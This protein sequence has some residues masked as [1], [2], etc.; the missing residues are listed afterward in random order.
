MPLYSFRLYVPASPD[1]VV[2]R[3]RAIVREC[4]SFWESLRG[5]WLRTN[6]SG[7]PFLGSVKGNSFHLCRN[8]NYRNSFL[9]RIRGR[10]GSVQG[11]AR[12]G[13]VMFMHPLVFLFMLGWLGSVGYGA[14]REFGAT[15][16]L[17]YIPV[18]MFIFGLALSMGG[19][20]PE[21]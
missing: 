7:P 16:A 3:L 17:S 13:V 5:S 10:V 9:P 18:V 8:I 14:W 19:F 20:F 15:S 12:V 11:G 2:E 6:P 21:A 4:P 1:V